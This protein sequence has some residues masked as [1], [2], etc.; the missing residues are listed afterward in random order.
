MLCFLKGWDFLLL[1]NAIQCEQLS[2]T[3]QSCIN[4]K[5]MESKIKEAKIQAHFKSLPF[6]KTGVKQ[7]EV[8]GSNKVL[9][10]MQLQI[11]A[12]WNLAFPSLLP[13]TLHSCHTCPAHLLE[14]DNG[15]KG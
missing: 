14:A 12:F 9:P 13:L 10:W 4:Q 5:Q 1:K 3:F 8:G 7:L 11:P 15:D 2:L 6:K